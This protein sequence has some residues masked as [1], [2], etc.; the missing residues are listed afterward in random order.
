MS[1]PAFPKRL[2]LV[3]SIDGHPSYPLRAYYINS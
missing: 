3:D 2:S 1:L